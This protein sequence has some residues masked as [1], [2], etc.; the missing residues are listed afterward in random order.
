MLVNCCCALSNCGVSGSFKEKASWY[1]RVGMNMS[2]GG[3]IIEM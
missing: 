1:R 2:A 3:E